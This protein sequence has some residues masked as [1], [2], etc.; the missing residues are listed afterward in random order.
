[1]TLDKSLLR[2]Y[3]VTSNDISRI[4]QKTEQILLGGAKTVQ[5]RL[6]NVPAPQ[7]IEIGKK[8]LPLF[9]KHGA[10]LIVNDD[11]KTALE[12]GADGV[13]IGQADG[14]IKEIRQQIGASKILGVS[15]HCVEEAKE[16]EHLGAD[17]IGAGALFSTSTKNNTTPLKLSTLHSICNS[18]S[19]PTVAIG[20]INENNVCSL[21]GSGI[22]GIAVSNAV[23]N[24]SDVLSATKKLSALAEAIINSR[25]I[26]GAIF[27]MDGT[28]I[29][30]MPKW[31]I[32][33]QDFLISVGKTP[34]DDL[35]EI[36][37]PMSVQNAAKYFIS[38]YG[39]NLSVDEITDGINNQMQDYYLNEFELKCGTREF[40]EFFA[41]LGIKMCIATATDRRLATAALKRN[42][43]LGFFDEIFTC[44]ELNCSKREPTIFEAALDFLGTK[45]ERTYV[46]EDSF[47]AIDA[48]KKAGFKVAAVYDEA[49]LEFSSQIEKTADIYSTLE[50]MRHTF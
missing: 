7:I 33:A 2:L 27:D 14:D 5:L 41:S 19:I 8:L 25:N 49:A 48:A 42:G 40:L 3:A 9:R 13:H 29:D 12:I 20:G 15:T 11:V 23:F 50:E 24:S 4:E 45:K 26:D 46:F 34:R 35:G 32:V 1:M 31:S 47:F 37:K 39:V 17:Y 10:L 44:G 38:D 21:R 43:I 28:L 6:K 30:S 22:S 18:V 36:I 16:A